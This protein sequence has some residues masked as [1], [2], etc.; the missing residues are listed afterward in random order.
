[1]DNQTI[2]RTPIPILSL[3]EI[4]GG[5]KNESWGT[6]LREAVWREMPAAA[7]PAAPVL[8]LE[9]DFLGCWAKKVGEDISAEGDSLNPKGREHQR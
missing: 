8:R 3:K 7:A 1:M 9:E 4:R 2:K 6:W 5:A